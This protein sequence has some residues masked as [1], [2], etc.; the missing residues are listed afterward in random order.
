[1]SPAAMIPDRYN[2]LTHKRERLCRKCEWW[3]SI[4]RFGFANKRRRHVCKT[5]RADQTL[6]QVQA[7]R[8]RQ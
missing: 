5:C 3:L 1:M 8:A 4:E 2:P 6:P 7:W